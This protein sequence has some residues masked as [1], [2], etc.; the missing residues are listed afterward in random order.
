MQFIASL[1][2]LLTPVA[3]ALPTSVVTE[4]EAE[5]ETRQCFVTCG[6]TCY[7]SSQVS[8]ARSTGYSYYQSNGQAGS[9]NY[10]HTYNNFEGFDFLVS[11]PYQEFPLRTSGAYTGGKLTAWRGWWIVLTG[12]FR[13]T[14]CGS[15]YFQHS[16]SEGGRDHAHWRFGQ[17][18]CCLLRMV[19]FGLAY[20]GFHE[21]IQFLG[22][23]GLLCDEFVFDVTT[24]WWLPA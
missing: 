24:D 20:G 2:L 16:G 10:P 21:T 11:G 13:I 9:S 19:D 22:D 23:G 8:A 12:C 14:G 17:Q 3:L 7:T 6:S 4:V 1:L 15:C 5:I 18:L